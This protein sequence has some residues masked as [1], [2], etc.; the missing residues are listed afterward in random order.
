MTLPLTP[1]PDRP[2]EPPPPL[3]PGPLNCLES[4]N[5]ICSKLL[6]SSGS[7]TEPK[8]PPNAKVAKQKDLKS[9]YPKAA[10]ANLPVPK[11]TLASKT[12]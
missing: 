6:Q 12:P 2:M 3:R 7:G 8:C 5:E 4:P 9:S 11:A 1:Q 10:S